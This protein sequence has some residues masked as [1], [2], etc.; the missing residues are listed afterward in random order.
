MADPTTPQG[1]PYPS[2]FPTNMTPA[3]K[4]AALTQS[5]NLGSLADNQND[6]DSMLA[7]L[8]QPQEHHSFLGG[9]LPG[10]AAAGAEIGKG[11]THNKQDAGRAAF[12]HAMF[13]GQ[14]QPD[15]G[16]GA[17]LGGGSP[18]LANPNAQGINPWQG[19]GSPSLANP[20]AQG[21]GQSAIA[22]GGL[23]AAVSQLTP[24][25]YAAAL[26]AENPSAYVNQ[27]HSRM[28]AQLNAAFAKSNVAASDPESI[29]NT[30]AQV[31]YGDAARQSSGVAGENDATNARLRY[32]LAGNDR[33]DPKSFNTA[34]SAPSPTENPDPRRDYQRYLD[35]GSPALRSDVP[36]PVSGDNNS[37]ADATKYARSAPIPPLDDTL[38]GA[39]VSRSQDL[40]PPDLDAQIAALRN[41]APA[42]HHPH[43][44]FGPISVTRKP[45]LRAQDIPPS[46]PLDLYG[47]AISRPAAPPAKKSGEPTSLPVPGGYPLDPYE[48]AGFFH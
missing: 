20:N 4:Q 30:L 36:L 34:P 8:R 26:R 29:D 35:A 10:V 45:Q 42:A 23:D 13:D 47:Q 11:L 44:A 32:F 46:L 25:D 2:L 3:Q 5:M 1:N 14:G 21:G 43:V 16:S 22:P 12:V 24:D 27:P 48:R 15:S 40:E 7:A 37:L 39:P 19:G 9:I 38:S 31:M 17:W 6:Y 41:Q 28:G 18:S 33:A